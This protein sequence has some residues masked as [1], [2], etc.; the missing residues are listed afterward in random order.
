MDR[1]LV[2]IPAFRRVD[3]LAEIITAFLAEVSIECRILVS[4]DCEPE[5]QRNFQKLKDKFNANA[6][7]SFVF[8]K[9]RIGAYQN[10]QFCLNPELPSK[11][12]ATYLFFCEDDIVPRENLVPYLIDLNIQDRHRSICICASGIIGTGRFYFY[13]SAIVP[14]WGMLFSPIQLL[15][16]NGSP[17]TKSEQL[18]FTKSILFNISLLATSPLHFLQWYKVFF[19]RQEL[20][21]GDISIFYRNIYHRSRAL[22]PTH[23][24]IRNEGFE[25]SASNMLPKYSKF[26][27][28]IEVDT[29]PKFQAMIRKR[30]LWDIIYFTFRRWLY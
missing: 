22:I 1:V 2:T 17:L 16:F 15:H 9:T 24:L 12:G 4:V 20:S 25:A 18:Q 21:Y 11:F 5:H 8:H 30:P 23:T 7:V 13:P 26:F 3:T 6:E 19:K 10:Y 14:A 28:D 29:V 27:K